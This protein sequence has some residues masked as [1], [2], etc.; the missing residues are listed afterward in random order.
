M[1]TRLQRRARRQRRKVRERRQRCRIWKFPDGRS[2]YFSG[3]A[4]EIANETFSDS[5]G[6]PDDYERKRREVV[7]GAVAAIGRLERWSRDAL[8]TPTAAER[9]QD[10]MARGPT[11]VSPQT[12]LRLQRELIRQGL[13]EVRSVEAGADERAR[14]DSRFASEPTPLSELIDNV[15]LAHAVSREHTVASLGEIAS[16]EYERRNPFSSAAEEIARLR[17]GIR[18]DPAE[19]PLA[20][21]EDSLD[22]IEQVK[23]NCRESPDTIVRKVRGEDVEIFIGGE[24]VTDA[25][26]FTSIEYGWRPTGA[27]VRHAKLVKKWRKK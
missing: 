2:V 17:A 4:K 15:M 1:S 14:V 6:S 8:A 22:A 12:K 26:G 3:D 18:I 7:D 20:P 10:A 19:M 11:I 16:R 25:I 27:A 21:L 5:F 9:L 13:L 24:R 23:A